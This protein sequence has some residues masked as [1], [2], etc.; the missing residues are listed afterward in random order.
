MAAFPPTLLPLFLYCIPR[1]FCPRSSFFF[2]V[3]CF[4][5]AVFGSLRGSH[6]T[7]AAANKLNIHSDIYLSGSEVCVGGFLPASCLCT[8]PLFADIPLRFCLRCG[9]F[10]ARCLRCLYLYVSTVADRCEERLAIDTYCVLL[11][12]ISFGRRARWMGK[13]LSSGA[14]GWPAYRNTCVG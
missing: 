9:F 7:S 4:C 11:R 3:V 6:H 1:A 8:V 5:P 2:V 12:D 14:E 10:L 13:P